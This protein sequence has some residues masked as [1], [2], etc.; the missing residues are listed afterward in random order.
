MTAIAILADTSDANNSDGETAAAYGLFPAANFYL[1]TGECDDCP[2]IPQALWFFQHQIIALPLPGLPVA[3]FER[4]LRVT[5]D[6]RQWCARTPP[7]SARDYPALVWIGSPQVLA[8][9]LDS[10]GCKLQTTGGALDFRLVPRLESNR[11]FYNAA[12]TAF[13]TRRDVR[14]RG[15]VKGE[16][17][18]AR[19]LWPLDWR[20]AAD[21]VLDP[22]PASP[23]ALRDY[24]RTGTDAAT[25]NNFANRLIW[26][27]DPSA[28]LQ[29]RGRPLLGFVLNG[30]QGDDD[31][32]HGG[33]FGVFTGRVGA[34]GEFHDCLLANFYTLDTESE[35]GI[36]SAMLPLDNYLV[37]VNSGQSW[38]RPSWLL[39]AT[40]RD[41]RT[42]LH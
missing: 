21:A 26:Q 18:V 4:R 8:G 22:L 38:Y 3:G 33:H 31:E 23:A 34:N 20:L 13:F 12:S 6:L 2:A 24:V 11:S 25:R 42:A 7:G 28:A 16:T 5:D 19:T 14:V 17:L 35:K 41:E 39:V 30:A 1:T 15:T 10:E 32:A 37:D 9:R 29:R 36:I 27:R 40:L